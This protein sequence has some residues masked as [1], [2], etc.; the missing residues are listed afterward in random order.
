[1]PCSQELSKAQEIL[2]QLTASAQC[3][4]GVHHHAQHDALPA[5][6]NVWICSP[7][8]ILAYS[9]R[10]AGANRHKTGFSREARLVCSRWHQL[11]EVL[12][13][14]H[15]PLM[16]LR[17][18][19]PAHSSA[20]QHSQQV[21]ADGSALR[22]DAPPAPSPAHRIRLTGSCRASVL[23]PNTQNRSSS[24][25]RSSLA[26][27]TCCRPWPTRSMTS[28]T[29]QPHELSQQC[30]Q[31][32][33][34]T[35]ELFQKRMMSTT[36]GLLCLSLCRQAVKQLLAQTDSLCTTPTSCC[37]TRRASQ[38]QLNVREAVVPTACSERMLHM[39][40]VCACCVCMGRTRWS[41]RAGAA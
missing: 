32:C 41:G 36:A 2:P 40:A 34:Q 4:K 14:S 18:R 26:S 20:A 31:Q 38:A 29:L 24:C 16:P 19:V 15:S 21:R 30:T 12:Q 3:T 22:A 17:L 35:H 33:T 10:R 25:M 6:P 39:H 9:G 28:P 1:M 8:G 37:D 27:S 11:R 7:S 5:Q 13:L 23:F